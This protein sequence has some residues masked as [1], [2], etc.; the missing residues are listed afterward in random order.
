MSTKEKFE[1]RVRETPLIDRLKESVSRIGKM[2]SKGEPPS[3]TIPLHPF[4]DDFFIT[5]TIQDAIDSL[6]AMPINVVFDAP[7]GLEPGR[8]VE[9]ET[10]DGKSIDAGEWIERSDGLYALRITSLPSKL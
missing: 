6:E 3:M 5:T 1:A 7:P 9:V 2:C 4:D 8:F 10:D